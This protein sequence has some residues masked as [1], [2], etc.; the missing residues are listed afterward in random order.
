MAAIMP[1]KD[2]PSA[3]GIVGEATDINGRPNANNVRFVCPHCSAFAQHMFGEVV[4][5]QRGINAANMFDIPNNVNVIMA[6]CTSCGGL[7]IWADAA[8]VFPEDAG[9]APLAAQDM[10]GSIVG[11]FE[12]ARSIYRKS[13]RGAA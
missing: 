11:D 9:D 6:T 2:L 12:E 8:L 10:P 13:P 1:E 5:F 4:R 3:A 7:S